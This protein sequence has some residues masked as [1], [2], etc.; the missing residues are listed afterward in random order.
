LGE[1]KLTPL[2]QARR[3]KKH[4]DSR[5]ARGKSPPGERGVR[6]SPFGENHA[7]KG[8]ALEERRE[9]GQKKRIGGF[10]YV[11]IYSYTN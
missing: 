4:S 2:E 1:K 9:E 10:A 7:H 6:P 3:N 5:G 8:G 11:R